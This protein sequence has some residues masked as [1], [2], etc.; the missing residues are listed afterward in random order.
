MRYVIGIDVGTSGTKMVLFDE[1][2]TVVASATGEYPMYQPQNGY[3]EQDPS[4]SK[5]NG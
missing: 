1:V 3:A 4:Y 5:S 2:G